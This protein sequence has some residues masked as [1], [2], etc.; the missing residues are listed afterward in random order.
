LNFIGI[1]IRQRGAGFNTP[2]ASDDARLKPVAERLSALLGAPVA[3]SR[4][5][6]GAEAET[7]VAALRDGQVL[8]LEN[9]RFHAE[10]ERNDPA[11]AKQ[12]ADLADIYVND[13]F[14]RMLGYRRSKVM[15]TKC[16]SLVAP[17]HREILRERMAKRLAGEQ[18][19]SRYFFQ[20]LA[21][22]GRKI[23]IEVAISLLDMNSGP[24][25]ILGIYRDVTEQRR[26]ERELIEYKSRLERMVKERTA[27]LATANRDLKRLIAE[28][29]RN[30]AALERKNVALQE[31][32]DRINVEKDRIKDDIARNVEKL[33]LPALWRLRRSARGVEGAY[34]SSLEKNLKDLASSFGRR[35]SAP[36]LSLSPREIEVCNLVRN[37]LTSKDIAGSLGVSQK[38]I[39]RHRDNIR[40]KLK[41][42]GRRV[43]L[44]SRLQSL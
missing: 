22:D 14:C 24:P 13:A 11:F 34:L 44:V 25:A 42:S 4:D 33:L 37:G 18:V 6:V 2:H 40:K 26:M 19:P 31:I 3:C 29:K 43:N 12:L 21:R 39:C 8:L 32:L 17:D 36:G 20:A 38:T 41:I 27:Q 7:A 23:D 28:R 15:G 9:L 1:G 16:F 35:V 5:C 30:E 10:E